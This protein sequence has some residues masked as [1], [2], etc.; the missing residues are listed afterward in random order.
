MIDPRHIISFIEGRLRLRHPALRNAT[1][2]ELVTAALGRKEG[3]LSAV[4][5]P[6]VGSLLLF[7]DPKKISR[8]KL[9]KMTEESMTF[10]SETQ[11]AQGGQGSRE[12]KI[13]EGGNTFGQ[14]LSLCFF[15][16]RVTRMTNR[17][18]LGTFL[19]SLAGAVLGRFSLHVLAGGLFTVA[20]VQHL[21]AHKNAL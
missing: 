1:V 9:M 15:S 13:E 10:L 21:L 11:H 16:H 18:M 6:R 8:D 5:N 20:G 19:L 14:A 3:V 2:V 12:K 17:I 4:V 7:Y